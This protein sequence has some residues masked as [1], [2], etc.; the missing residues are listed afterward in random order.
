MYCKCFKSCDCKTPHH[1]PTQKL[2]FGVM[3]LYVVVFNM[4]GQ[5]SAMLVF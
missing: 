5:T 3:M 2:E 4:K 1:A